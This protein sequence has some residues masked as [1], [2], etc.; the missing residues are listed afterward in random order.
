PSSQPNW[1]LGAIFQRQLDREQN[2]PLP[3]EQYED[4]RLDKLSRTKSIYTLSSQTPKQPHLFAADVETLKKYAEKEGLG[5][6]QTQVRELSGPEVSH[7]FRE[8]ERI[9]R[10]EKDKTLAD[11]SF[12]ESDLSKTQQNTPI[13]GLTG[14][15][16]TTVF[17]TN[18]MSPLFPEQPIRT[19]IR[20]NL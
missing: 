13:S 9:A 1:S 18:P 10:N 4:E 14:G 16:G 11:I 3:V 12:I 17:D 2:K 8:R 15:S 7:M 5:F 6:D 19:D 20:P